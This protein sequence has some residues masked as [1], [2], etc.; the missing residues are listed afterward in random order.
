MVALMLAPDDIQTSC[1]YVGSRNPPILY[2]PNLL[3]TL[4]I[5]LHSFP[6]APLTLVTGKLGLGVGAKQQAFY[7]GG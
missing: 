6:V 5:Y 2:G 4:H 3:Y 7:F 1:G